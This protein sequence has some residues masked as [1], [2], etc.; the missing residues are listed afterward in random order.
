MKD[1]L[2]KTKSL[3]VRVS[4]VEISLLKALCL[5]RGLSE[6]EAVRQSIRSDALNQGIYLIDEKL[7][8]ARFDQEMPAMA[9]V[10]SGYQPG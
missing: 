10:E 5:R 8:V 3:R 2:K 1:R 4:P 9:E 7:F 6:S